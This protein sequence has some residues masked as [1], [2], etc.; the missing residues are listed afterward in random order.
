LEILRLYFPALNESLGRQVVAFVRKLRLEKLKKHPSISE[1]IDWT[2]A[3]T[4][5]EAKALTAGLVMTTLNVLIKYHEDW[6]KITAKI[7]DKDWFGGIS[8]T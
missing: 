6:Q 2:T 8:H 4:G 1:V 7:Q 5:M 3:L